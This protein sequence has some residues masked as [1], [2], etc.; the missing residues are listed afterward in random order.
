MK[1]AKQKVSEAA[2]LARDAKLDLERAQRRIS[3]AWGR[4][5]VAAAEAYNLAHNPPQA[6]AVPLLGPPYAVACCPS[7]SKL[8]DLSRPAKCTFIMARGLRVN[9]AIQGLR[10]N[11]ICC[12]CS[13]EFTIHFGDTYDAS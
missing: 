7:C 6:P 3:E 10:M 2:D 11:Y 12:R 13:T 4:L 8:P 5:D 1:D 9:P